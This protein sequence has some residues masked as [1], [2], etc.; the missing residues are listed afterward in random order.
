D[1]EVNVNR[2]QRLQRNNRIA[3]SHILTEVRLT[4]PKHAGEWSTDGLAI[5]GGANLAYFGVGRF[6]FSSCLIV[7]RTRDHA[8]IH[9][10]LSAGEVDAREIALRL[11]IGELG[12][13]LTSIQFNKD[14]TLMDGGAGLECDLLN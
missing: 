2:I 9:E 7:I 6:L 14:I 8:F 11:C 12:A 13:L 1:P 4:N 5:D 10:T 3:S